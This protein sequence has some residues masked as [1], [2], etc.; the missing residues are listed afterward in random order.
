VQVPEGKRWNGEIMERWKN[1]ILEW[2]NRN[3]RLKIEDWKIGRL[4]PWNG[5]KWGHIL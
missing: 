3:W 2:K 4:D 5:T 1:G